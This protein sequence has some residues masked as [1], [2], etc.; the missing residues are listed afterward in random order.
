M[1][2]KAVAPAILLIVDEPDTKQKVFVEE[3]SAFYGIVITSTPDDTVSPRRRAYL[4]VFL[5]DLL[6]PVG[7][8]KVSLPI[9]ARYILVVVTETGGTSRSDSTLL[10]EDFAAKDLARNPITKDLIRWDCQQDNMHGQIGLPQEKTPI[11]HSFSALFAYFPQH[12]HLVSAQVGMLSFFQASSVREL[13]GN[14]P[15]FLH[16]LNEKAQVYFESS[17]VNAKRQQEKFLFSL[18]IQSPGVSGFS[19]VQLSF[20][21]IPYPASLGA[22][23][24]MDCTISQW[25]IPPRHTS[26]SKARPTIPDREAFY[27]ASKVL[28]AQEEKGP[29]LY[30]R[31][32][33]LQFQ[34]YVEHYGREQGDHF[35]LHCAIF[36]DQWLKGI[37]TFGHLYSDHFAFVVSEKDFDP[38][39]F[40]QESNRALGF[41]ERYLDLS[42]ALGIA[43]VSDGSLPIDHLNKMA[44][45]ALYSVTH[46][47]CE[48]RF[49]FYELRKGEESL[50][51]QRLFEEIPFALKTL[52]IGIYLQPVFNPE[53]QRF[54]SAEALARW[55][56]PIYGLLDPKVFIPLFEKRNMIQELDLSIL[57]SVCILQQSLVASGIVPLPIS[58]NLS[59]LDFYNSKLFEAILAIVDNHSLSHALICFEITES[60][61]MDNPKQILHTLALL[62]EQG[63]LLL[64]DDYGSGYS[65]L[66]LLTSSPI[67]I[68]KIDREFTQ[69][70]GM[71][72]KVETALQ[73]VA[74]LVKNLGIEMIAEGVENAVQADFFESIGCS[75]IQGYFYAK[76]MPVQSYRLALQSMQAALPAVDNSHE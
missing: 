60:T 6:S 36:L 38:D 9:D 34:Q 71:S 61:Y 54:V 73:T 12:L 15:N 40:L 26:Y 72:S 17:L 53:K 46:G 45:L 48:H 10:P 74:A 51:N 43:R 67:D 23:F 16:L 44:K 76:P 37:G 39:A 7:Y 24:M 8:Q 52:Q 49:A 66:R 62:R 58:V 13:Q 69:Q 63:F 3:L 14:I 28:L 4:A 42:T 19:Q 22:E 25:K 55:N 30:V 75:L 59:Q 32:Q 5:G 56:H 68:L 33:I 47:H 11:S 21:P 50:R 27:D 2:R 29:F 18:M 57:E 65:S 1:I 41:A 35:L 64:L 70:V 31:W 20:T